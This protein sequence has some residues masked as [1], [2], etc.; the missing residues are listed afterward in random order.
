MPYNCTC[1]ALFIVEGG[2]VF[3]FKLPQWHFTRVTSPNM[4]FYSYCANIT[5]KS[6]GAMKEVVGPKY[7]IARSP[8]LDLY[9]YIFH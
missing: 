9:Q 6:K 7:S 3:P 4:L 1:R 5:L 2:G 8:R